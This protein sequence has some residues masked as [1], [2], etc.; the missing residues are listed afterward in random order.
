MDLGFKHYRLTTPTA[1]TLD[2]IIEFDPT[3]PQQLDLFENM[4]DKLGGLDCILQT[5]LIDDGYTFDRKPQVIDFE[6][7][8]AF[9][10]DNSVLYLISSGWE[11]RQTEKLLNLV[12]KNELN[13]NTIF[14]FGYSFS[15]E[16][17]R[18]LKLNVK[19]NLNRQV[20]IEIRY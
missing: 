15:M 11:G 9:Y 19:N 14:V 1:E 3:R 7:Y 18:E 16:S 5:W 13:L 10:I 6:G 4:V 12:G 8:N 17:L 20:H 2:R